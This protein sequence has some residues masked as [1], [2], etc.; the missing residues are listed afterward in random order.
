MRIR[1]GPD[2]RGAAAVVEWE[3]AERTPETWPALQEQP[4]N[5]IRLACRTCILAAAALAAAVLAAAAL[6]LGVGPAAASAAPAAQASTVSQIA[7]LPPSP[8]VP[9][10]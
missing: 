5:R 9:V 2:P 8:C 4:M 10:L 6:A 1:A 7:A 3:P